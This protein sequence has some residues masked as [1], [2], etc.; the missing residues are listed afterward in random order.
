VSCERCGSM[1]D[2]PARCS[3]ACEV[4][5]YEKHQ[6]RLRVNAVWGDDVGITWENAT[7]E[8]REHFALTRL[9]WFFRLILHHEGEPAFADEL[10]AEVFAQAKEAAEWFGPILKARAEAAGIGTG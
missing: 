6:L 10:D 5:A 8:Q 1:E 2:V 7:V 4:A 3:H 9:F